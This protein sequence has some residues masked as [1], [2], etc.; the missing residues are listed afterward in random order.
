MYDKWYNLIENCPFVAYIVVFG[1]CFVYGKIRGKHGSHFI[2]N[3]T[4][5]RV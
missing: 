3:N 5:S 2:N 4:R 1:I